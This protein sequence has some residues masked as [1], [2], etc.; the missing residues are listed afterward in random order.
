MLN[1]SD[2]GAHTAGK[3]STETSEGKSSLDSREPQRPASA[4][5][6]VAASIQ[7]LHESLLAT[8][9]AA[10]P[11]QAQD[12]DNQSSRQQHW[13]SGYVHEMHSLQRCSTRVASLASRANAEYT[14]PFSRTVLEKE[15][16]IHMRA[17]LE[18]HQTTQALSASQ[19][20]GV[21]G[22]K[23]EAKPLGA[24]ISTLCVDRM[25]LITSLSL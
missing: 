8:D 11:A 14:A 10:G 23:V 13:L 1:A 16:V 20:A 17:C 9:T 6:C 4:P 19:E 25:V 2:Q 5:P 21:L 12:G 22:L 15:W 18:E 24:L 3:L 7:Q